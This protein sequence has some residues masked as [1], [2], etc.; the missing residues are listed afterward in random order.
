MTDHFFRLSIYENLRFFSSCNESFKEERISEVLGFLD[1][2]NKKDALYMTLSSGEK[3]KVSFARAILRGAKI[4]LFDEVTSN[5]DIVAKKEIMDF[6]KKLLDEK[7]VEAVIFST[8]SLEEVLKL[9]S[10]IIMLGN[11]VP[12]REIEVKNEL[13]I[14]EIREL[15]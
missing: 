12:M 6:I 13:S 10:K 1:L 15:F 4:L 8:H 5:L 9:A 2:L 3:K 14:K 11:N 7:K